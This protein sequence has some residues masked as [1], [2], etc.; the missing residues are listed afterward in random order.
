M[1]RVFVTIILFNNVH[2]LL[3]FERASFIHFVA[4]YVSRPIHSVYFIP[5]HFRF[6]LQ[7]NRARR[8]P[9]ICPKRIVFV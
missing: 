1:L 7:V 9:S 2:V 3:M 4:E 5:P 8:A 6:V